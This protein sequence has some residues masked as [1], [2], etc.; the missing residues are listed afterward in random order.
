MAKPWETAASAPG[1]PAPDS[2]KTRPWAKAT[3]PPA[4]PPLSPEDRKLHEDRAAAASAESEKYRKEGETFKRR[5]EFLRPAMRLGASVNRALL[6]PAAM[7]ESGAKALG[8]MNLPGP[9]KA[10]GA[11]TD[12]IGTPFND[13]Y[14]ANVPDNIPGLEDRNALEGFATRAEEMVLG[15]GTGVGVA[16]NV[17]RQGATTASRELGQMMADQPVRQM[18]AATTGAAGG[19]TVE[20]AGG[21]P[22]AQ[23]LGTLFGGAAALPGAGTKARAPRPEAG[24]PLPKPATKP[25]EVARAA[26]MVT[27]PSATP[28]AKGNMLESLV[29][30]PQAS[31]KASLK[32]QAQL[33]RHARAELGLQG[34]QGLSTQ[35]Y[36][37]LEKP[38]HAVYDEVRNTVPTL[39]IDEPLAAAIDGVGKAARDNPLLEV[40]PEV[41]KLQA[42]L[43]KQDGTLQTKDVM[44]AVRSWRFKAGKLYASADDP[45]KHEQAQAFQSAANAFED[46][47]ER[48]AAAVGKGD[49]GQRFRDARTAL[50]KIYDYESATVDGMIDASILEKL[51]KAGKPLSGRA[52]MIADLAR[53]FGPETQHQSTV[54]MPTERMPPWWRSAIGRAIQIMGR[55]PVDEILFGDKYQGQFGSVDQAPGPGSPLGAYFDAPPAPA[56][57]KG[58]SGPSGAGSVDFERSPEVPPVRAFREDDIEFAR[59]ESGDAAIPPAEGRLGDLTASAPP[60]PRGDIDFEASPEVSNVQG[61]P[62]PT[63]PEAGVAEGQAGFPGAEVPPNAALVEWLTDQPIE[64]RV[65]GGRPLVEEPNPA[66]QGDSTRAFIDDGNP[67]TAPG[68]PGD[69]EPL[70][71]AEEYPIPDRSAERDRVLANDG[72]FNAESML[73]DL[74]AR[75]PGLV[76]EVRGDTVSNANLARSR[77]ITDRGGNPV[78]RTPEMPARRAGE[79]TVLNIGHN[80]GDKVGLTT[81]QIEQALTKI[82]VKI[83]AHEV[84][85]SGTEPTSIIKLDRALTPEE[86]NALAVELKQQAIAQRSGG[87]GALHGPEAAAWGDFN[88]EFFLDLTGKPNGKP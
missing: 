55:T 37:N 35:T 65:Q 78:E 70:S 15:A 26:G 39:A 48:Q 3:P 87:V 75:F 28:G 8:D 82:G 46:A 34:E 11:L 44:E 23:L 27:P 42:R 19:E 2:G 17:A 1:V 85:Q 6:G 71:F 13:A 31:A 24:P 12:L 38:Q 10:A 80:V 43:S 18:T 14:N 52:D 77:R 33:D 50:A 54:R 88:P 79:E 86:A 59:D 20:Q 62:A 5:N 40:G 58:P 84:R 21:G 30:S 66:F 49:L 51:K 36:R 53:W 63:A 83:D 9:L 67:A 7:L 81:Q 47:I 41:T 29:G 25:A 16:Q 68:R 60:A 72:G 22:I 61:R 45:A 76:A 32:N 57:P 69:P 4:R 56:K 74:F 73:G 64:R